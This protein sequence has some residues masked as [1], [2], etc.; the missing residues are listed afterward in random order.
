MSTGGPLDGR[1]GASENAERD[2]ML[3]DGTNLTSVTIE[4]TPLRAPNLHDRG[5]FHATAEAGD[6]V[7]SRELPP[8]P[9]RKTAQ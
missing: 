5:G 3:T 1:P 9:I 6:A 2:G 4:L 8:G 7:G